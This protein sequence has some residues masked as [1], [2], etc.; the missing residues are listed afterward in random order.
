MI[1]IALYQPDI[2][3]NAGATMRLC[4]CLGMGLDIIEP[5]GFA[6]DNK[7]LK[8]SGMDY[9]DELDMIRHKSWDHFKEHYPKNRI[10]LLSTKASAPYIEVNF[11]DGDILLAGQESAGVPEHVHNSVDQRILIPMP[12]GGR[13]INVVNS[14][15]M[16]SGEALRQTGGFIK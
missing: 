3:Q 5:C 16:V 13:S 2:P 10:L 12:G 7:K 14:L 4:R 11:E 1:R 15:A 8:R 9:I 6:L